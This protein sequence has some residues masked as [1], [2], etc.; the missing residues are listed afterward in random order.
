VALTPG[1]AATLAALAAGVAGAAWVASAWDPTWALVMA[2]A[3]A[4]FGALSGLVYSRRLMF[5]AAASPHAAFLAAAAAVP[6]SAALPGP[7]WAWLALVGLAIVYAVGALVYRGVDPDEATSLMV[8]FSASA[9]ALAAYIVLAK[10]RLGSSIAALVVGDPLLASPGEAAAAAA[11]AAGLVALAFLTAREAY[12]QGVDPEDA[13][14]S[15]LRVWAYDLAL[16]TMIGVAAVAMVRI[17]GFVLEH[18]LILV[19][20]AV[21]YHASRGIHRSLAVSTAAGAAGGLLG[22]AL[23][24]ALDLSPAPLAGLVLVALYAAARGG[25]RG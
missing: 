15:G 3:G 16:Y 8:S 18:A 14:L 17:V 9:G 6:L 4:G 13:R 12:Y 21:A 22:L 1:E 25:G 24:V 19:P 11:V 7:E 5:V 20:G 23:G 10:Y 2:S